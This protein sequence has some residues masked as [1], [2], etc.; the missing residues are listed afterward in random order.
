MHKSEKSAKRTITRRTALGGIALAAC[1][2]TVPILVRARSTPL[3]YNFSGPASDRKLDLKHPVR[4]TPGTSAQSEGPFYTP[5]TPR[6]T[7]L[8]EPDTGGEQLVLEGLILTPDCQPVAGAVIDIWH[9]DESGR[10]D[11]TGFRY[12]GHQF[13]DSAGAYRFETIRP[14]HYTGRTPHIH[15]KVQGMKTRLLTTQLYFPD[16]RDSNSRDW[17]QR[18]ELLMHLSRNGETWFGRYDFMLDKLT[19]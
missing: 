16:L 10:Y 8:R 6:R 2:A 15:V 5:R 7:V 9:C 3:N 13:T 4:C 12:R 18:D 19:F 1:T 14:G 17:L 11:N